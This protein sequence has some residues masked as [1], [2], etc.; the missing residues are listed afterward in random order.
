M[1]RPDCYCP[2]R[3]GT[4][5]TVVRGTGRISA[6]RPVAG[7]RVPRLRG[8]AVRPDRVAARP[9]ARHLVPRGGRDPGRDH[10]R[11]VHDLAALPGPARPDL[12][13]AVR[14]TQETR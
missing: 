10:P 14:T 6:G 5:E 4:A 7:L 13:D 11:D 12:D 1:R 2:G 8:A 3:D 9:L